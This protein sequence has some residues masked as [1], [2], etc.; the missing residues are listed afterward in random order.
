M[1]IFGRGVLTE[2]QLTDAVDLSL[3]DWYFDLSRKI[4]TTVFGI[5]SKTRLLKFGCELA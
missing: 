4:A 2:W 5:S 1:I 3:F